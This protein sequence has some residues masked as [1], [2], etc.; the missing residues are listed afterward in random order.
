MC[1]L[2]TDTPELLESISYCNKYVTRVIVFFIA[3]FMGHYA[4]EWGYSFLKIG[5]QCPLEN[6]LSKGSD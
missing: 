3:K 2:L 6:F 1:C 5:H 4:K